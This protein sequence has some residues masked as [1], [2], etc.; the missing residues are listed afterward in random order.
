[1]RGVPS[2]CRGGRPQCSDSWEELAIRLKFLYSDFRKHIFPFTGMPLGLSPLATPPHSLPA[3]LASF[4][5]RFAGEREGAERQRR[6]P[7]FVVTITCAL[8]SGLDRSFVNE[9]FSPFCFLICGPFCLKSLIPVEPSLFSILHLEVPRL[10]ATW[11]Q[12]YHGRLS[13]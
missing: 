3:A 5:R 4:I 1:M 13:V 12:T 9:G 2:T 10:V 6:I 11:L 7:R 8:P